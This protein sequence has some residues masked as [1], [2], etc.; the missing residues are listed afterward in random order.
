VTY[1]GLSVLVTGGTG[2]IGGRLAER[3]A[4]EEHA[5][6][7]ILIRDWRHAAWASRVP[8]AMVDGDVTQPKSLVDAVRGC[9]LIFHC[10]GVGGDHETC[11]RVNVEGTLN[12][13]R[14]AESAGI[15]RVIYLSS[16]AV[17]GPSPPDMADESA[18]LVR[19]GSA[20]GNSKI[21]A[22]E[23]IASFTSERT[24]PVVILR[25]TF[26]WGPRSQW[27]TINPIKQMLDGTFRLVD[28]GLGTCHAIYIDNLVDVML[29]AG[30]AQIVAGEKF[31]I[32]DDQPCT[33]AEFFLNYARM[34]GR[35]RLRSV[36]SAWL[37][38]PAVRTLNTHLERL[39]DWLGEHMPALALQRLPFRSARLMIR[40][41]LQ[42]LGGDCGLTEWDLKKYARRGGMNISWA[43]EQLGYRPRVNRAEGMRLTECWLRDQ[44]VI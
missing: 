10:V 16:I 35:C 41:G 21:A 19:F 25:P 13:L 40:H 28:H 32:T 30:L 3:L 18:P 8:A 1:A 33:W 15:R 11:R 22:E 38:Q 9:H 43:K 36:S 27:F 20:Y 5:N 29:R 39:Y 14:A 17:H 24:V 44:R 37:H 31:L 6:V 26:V 42:L 34:L 12:V 23:Y 2:F 7:R 4:F